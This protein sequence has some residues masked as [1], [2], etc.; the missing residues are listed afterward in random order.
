[1]TTVKVQR[2]YWKNN[3]DK[4][5]RH[6][7]YMS[8]YIKTDKGRLQNTIATRNFRKRHPLLR[9][10]RYRLMKRKG[11]CCVCERN[12]VEKGYVSCNECRVQRKNRYKKYLK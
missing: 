3:P 6:L 5:K 7:K 8:D 11:I 2:E 10:K 1:M 9:K 12:T 4:Y